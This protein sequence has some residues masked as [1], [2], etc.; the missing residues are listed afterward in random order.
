MAA[1]EAGTDGATPPRVTRIGAMGSFGAQNQ[2]HFT[3]VCPSA[4]A[5]VQKARSP[6]AGADDLV[7]DPGS[8]PSPETGRDRRPAGCPQRVEGH[9]AEE[10]RGLPDLPGT[11]HEDGGRRRAGPRP[12]C[13]LRRGGRPGRRRLPA[14]RARPRGTGRGVRS[15]S[16]CSRRHPPRPPPRSCRKPR[17]GTPPG[18]LSP[19]AVGAREG[20]AEACGGPCLTPPRDRAARCAGARSARGRRPGGPPDRRPGRRRLPR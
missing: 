5:R 14:R 15:P 13:R 18:A 6:R 9:P 17:R 19:A 11:E 3:T 12:R 8:V 4:A 10:P 16:R 1:R 7:T 20:R 2:E